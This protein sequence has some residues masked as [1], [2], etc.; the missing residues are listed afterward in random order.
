MPARAG[1]SYTTC[2]MLGSCWETCCWSTTTFIIFSCSCAVC[3][4]AL[5]MATLIVF[6]RALALISASPRVGNLDCSQ[7]WYESL[8]LQGLL[9][10]L[11][12]FGHRHHLP[13]LACFSQGRV[14][15]T[16][17]YMSC[18]QGPCIFSIFLCYSPCASHGNVDVTC[19][20]QVPFLYCLGWCQPCRQSSLHTMNLSSYHRIRQNNC[21]GVANEKA[22][23]RNTST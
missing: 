6:A 12:P 3:E 15:C 4:R 18:A 20:E 8:S 7:V 14:D 5:L 23:T 2:S 21:E 16:W 11:A 10:E 17:M 13:N 22:K 9:P 1:L 19:P